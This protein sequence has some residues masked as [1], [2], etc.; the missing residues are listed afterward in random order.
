VRPASRRIDVKAA[1]SRTRPKLLHQ[2]GDKFRLDYS[3]LAKQ[4]LSSYTDLV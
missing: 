3:Y 1:Q 4:N 2:S